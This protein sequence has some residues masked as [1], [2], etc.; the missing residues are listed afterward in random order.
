MLKCVK[1]LHSNWRLY[2]LEL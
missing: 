2:N 1:A